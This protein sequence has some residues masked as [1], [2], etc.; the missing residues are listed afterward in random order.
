MQVLLFGL[1][2]PECVGTAS[3]ATPNGRQR[4]RAMVDLDG[5]AY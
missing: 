2:W 4:K 3:K 1:V 5:V